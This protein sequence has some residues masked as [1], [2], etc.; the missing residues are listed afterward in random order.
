[1]K[2]P[3]LGTY[4]RIVITSENRTLTFTGSSVSLTGNT[5]IIS[6]TLTSKTSAGKLSK[7]TISARDYELTVKDCDLGLGSVSGKGNIT[8]NG[9][10]AAAV[11]AGRLDL[12][13][14]NRF[15]GTISA[16]ELYSETGAAIKIP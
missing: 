4:D 15:T 9:T 16:A 14:E 7:Y 2:L 11:K 3:K 6:T 12:E 8:L 10:A 1:M 5:D 13:G